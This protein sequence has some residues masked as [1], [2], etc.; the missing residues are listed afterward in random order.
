M[1]FEVLSPWAEADPVAVRGLV[2]RVADL[3][4][5]TI[6]LF[7]FFKAHAP[8]IMREVEKKLK[9]RFPTAKFSHY[10]YPYHVKEVIDDP[11]FK[12]SFQNWVK[13]VDTAVTGQGD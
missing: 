12:E 3:N 13:G 2:P 9:E 4:G 6:G 1:D 11:K 5:K 10:Q 7:S 8:F